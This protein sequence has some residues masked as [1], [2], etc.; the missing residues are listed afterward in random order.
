ME[1]RLNSMPFSTFSVV[2]FDLMLI[3]RKA[4]AVRPIG[5]VQFPFVYLPAVL[6]LDANNRFHSDRSLV[7]CEVDVSTIFRV[8]CLQRFICSYLNTA[9]FA[10]HSIIHTNLDSDSA[11]CRR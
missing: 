7:P 3:R 8:V 2:G 5:F 1:N 11:Y 4:S 9:F 6:P 10:V